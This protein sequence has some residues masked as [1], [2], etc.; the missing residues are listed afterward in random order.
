MF[1]LKARYF[2][3]SPPQT[4]KARPPLKG[5][6]WKLQM[7]LF[8]KYFDMS[9]NNAYHIVKSLCLR[10]WPI[11]TINPTRRISLPGGLPCMLVRDVQFLGCLGAFF[12][13]KVN[14]GVS[15][16]VKSQVVINFG[17]P[18]NPFAPPPK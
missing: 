12:E 6:T 15:F 2:A 13:Q 9:A 18:F 5:C 8:S 1:D 4:K 11:A 14:F 17:L 3:A 10:L 16:L 7:S